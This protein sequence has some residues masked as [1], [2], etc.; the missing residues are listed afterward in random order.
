M[1]YS[2]KCDKTYYIEDDLVTTGQLGALLG[3]TH[4]RIAEIIRRSGDFPRP[5][6]TLPNGTR[7]W[8]KNVALQWFLEHPRRA[9]RRSRVD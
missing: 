1:L 5:D 6:V 9:Y 3:V 2:N 4:Q 8:Y 7:L